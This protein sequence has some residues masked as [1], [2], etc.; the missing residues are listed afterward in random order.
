MKYEIL[1]KLILRTSL[2]DSF[3]F[4]LILVYLILILYQLIGYFLFNNPRGGNYEEVLQIV[5]NGINPNTH[6]TSHPGVRVM[7]WTFA[8]PFNVVCFL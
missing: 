1:T 8:N 4:Y 3:N 7:R 2:R 5:I 6:I